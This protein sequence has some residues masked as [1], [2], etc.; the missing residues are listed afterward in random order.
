[1][2][3]DSL[4][5]ELYNYVR[6]EL[7]IYSKES[8][9][10]LLTRYPNNE[11]VT[12][13]RGL[14][15]LKKDDYDNF[16]KKILIN[17]SHYDYHEIS[18]FSKDF[19]TAEDF[20]YFQKTYFP[21]EETFLLESYKNLFHENMYGYRGVV[22]EIEIEKGQGI[23]LDHFEHGLESEVI[24]PPDL[25]L[26]CK[27]HTI[28]PLKEQV[29]EID[30][31]D[32]ISNTSD[33]KDPM[34]LYLIN[35]HST[36]LN[37]VSRNNIL[38]MITFK[39]EGKLIEGDVFA[40]DNLIIFEQKQF[41]Y[42]KNEFDNVLSFVVPSFKDFAELGVMDDSMLKEIQDISNHIMI[43]AMTYYLENKDKKYCFK[44]LKNI[45]P[46]CNDHINDCYKKMVRE[47]KPS[48][49]DIQGKL[50]EKVNNPN[51]SQSD[52]NNLIENGMKEITSLIEGIIDSAPL[53]LDDLNKSK[54]NKDKKK[55]K[56]L[57][58]YKAKF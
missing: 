13:Y 35:N 38:N 49:D 57:K 27:I 29:K 8:I 56:V 4:D 36:D 30:I 14:N 43:E 42:S 15:F 26:P 48:Y 53:T 11:K 54:S 46:F 10:H 41:D 23:D 31:N 25:K 1:M 22:V 18:S 17:N 58:K 34:F 47:N 9:S 39:K 55:E 16:I 3:L 50:I 28:K 37:S 20:A 45:T 51:N 33:L 44:N 12:I 21:T 40:T 24:I 2:E 7:K 19:K 52:R 5:K 32:Y 6:N